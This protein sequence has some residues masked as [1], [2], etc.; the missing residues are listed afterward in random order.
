MFKDSDQ[1]LL[2]GAQGSWQDICRSIRIGFEFFRGFRQLRNTTPCVTVFGSARFQPHHP[3]YQMAR[4]MAQRLGKE[5][6]TI[7]TGG[8]PGIMEAANRGARDVGAKSYGCNIKLPVEQHPNPYLDVWA[9]FQ[10]FYVRKVMLVKYSCAFVV[11]PGGFG[12]MDEVFEML[13][14]IQTNKIKRFPIVA[15][16]TEYWTHLQDFIRHTMIEHG[17]IDVEDLSPLLITD[18]I[19]EAYEHIRHH[20]EYLCQT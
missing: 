5:G 4:D 15:M 12:T 19:E 10:H 6:F 1:R 17:T 14:L 8:G 16:G 2:Q 20:T 11:L 18:D 13:T 3:Y 9:E 7:M